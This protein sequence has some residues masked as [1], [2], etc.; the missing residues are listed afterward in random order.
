MAGRTAVGLDI[1]TSAVRAAQLT[2]GRQVTLDKLGQVALPEGAVRDGEV[3]DADAVS[4]AI[5]QL[6][7]QVRFSTKKVVLGVANSRVVVRQVDLPWL[8]ER[9]LKQSLPFQV[10]DALPMPVEAA[11]LD[12]YALQELTSDDGVRTVRGL[13]VAASREM[14]D[15]LVGAVTRAGLRPVMVD[16]TSFAVLRAAGRGLQ[17]DSDA[18]DAHPDAHPDALADSDHDAPTDTGID[19]EA[20]AGAVEAL[21]DIGAGVTNIVVHQR[22]VPRFVRILPMG[23]QDVTDALAQRLGVSGPEAEGLKREIGARAPDELARDADPETLRAFEDT[24]ST[25]ADEVRGTLDYYAAST[26]SG[27]VDRL[28]L[29]GGGSLLVGLPQR[30]HAVTRLPVRPGTPF[31]AL[32]IGST[33]L[34]PDQLRLVAPLSAVP[35]GL[36]L[37]A[38]A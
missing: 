17:A 9:E 20:A 37:G 34:D 13:L 10:Q 21:V 16:L 25:F 32:R 28:V 31:D 14:V 6:W 30:M 38:A 12:F 35:I 15:G 26:G 2:F 24:V 29:T 8:P 36:A 7:T 1:G 27:G 22:G 4:T 33:G 3:V 18:P 23:G 5:R 11:L 19:P